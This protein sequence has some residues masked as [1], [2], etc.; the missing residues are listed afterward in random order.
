MGFNRGSTLELLNGL[1]KLE[2]GEAE[3]A[4]AVDWGLEA[5]WTFFDSLIGTRS[6]FSK[7]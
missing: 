5:S 3:D 7:C 1:G 6:V 4:E 2:A